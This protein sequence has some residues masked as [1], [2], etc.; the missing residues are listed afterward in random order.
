[1]NKKEKESA[2][3]NEKMM[4]ILIIIMGSGAFGIFGVYMLVRTLINFSNGNMGFAFLQGII[5]GGFMGLWL[6]CIGIGQMNIRGIETQKKIDA[7]TQK[8]AMEYLAKK[9][10]VKE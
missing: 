8:K 10:E 4:G 9:I 3:N 6:L 7:E 5:A 1:M 2:F